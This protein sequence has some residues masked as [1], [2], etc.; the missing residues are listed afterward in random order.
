M[1]LREADE[2][3]TPALRPMKIVENSVDF[4]L[5]VQYSYKKDVFQHRKIMVYIIVFQ[6]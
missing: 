3:A 2:G 4:W 5:T 6:C 1:A